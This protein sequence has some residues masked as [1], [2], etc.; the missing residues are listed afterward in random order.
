MVA[1][2]KWGGALTTN[3]HNGIIS[4]WKFVFCLMIVIRHSKWLGYNETKLFIGGSIGVDFFFIVSGFLMAVSAFKNKNEESICRSTWKFLWRKIKKLFPYVLFSF[5][6]LLII[7][8]AID[9]RTIFEWVTGLWDLFLLGMAGFRMEDIN[10]ISWYIS[11]MLICMLVIYP[12]L[13]KYKDN[14]SL[15][16]APIIIILLGGYLSHEF[17]SLFIPYSWRGFYYKGLIRGFLAL[18][19]GVVCHYI[20]QKLK[21]IDFTKLGRYLLTGLE[22][23]CFISILVC[24]QTSEIPNSIYY[25]CLIIFAIGII[26]AFSQKTITYNFSCNKVFYFLEKVSLPMYLNQRFF[27]YLIANL[28]IFNRFNYYSKTLIFVILNFLFAI[29]TIYLIEFLLKKFQKLVTYLKP[30]LILNEGL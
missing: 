21:T 17:K 3:K 4:F 11:A 26:I 13:L 1:N 7:L 19:I 25:F 27:G 14:Y 18:N 15:L 2:S 5:V 23:I 9:S 24:A 29:I 12:L 28:D 30:K 22:I 8:I 10:V 16:I 20:C 6:L